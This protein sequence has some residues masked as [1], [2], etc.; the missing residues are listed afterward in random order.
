LSTGA[1]S[2]P[3]KAVFVLLTGLPGCV[4]FARVQGGGAFDATSNSNRSGGFAAVDAA[5]VPNAARWLDKKPFPIALHTGIDA[6][7]SERSA[8]FGWQTGLAYVPPP[9]PL[10]PY[11]LGGTSA[12]LGTRD[13]QTFFGMTSPYAEVGVRSLLGADPPDGVADRTFLT[14]A[15][16][17]A[18]YA[19]FL[20]PVRELADGFVLL[21]FGVGW[22]HE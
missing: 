4:G 7:F 15:L 3:W 13:R 19:N 14:M 22:G 6:I 10:A 9:R 16:S 18:S 2:C 12:H 21:K 11:F 20:G 1:F 8:V 5:G 17:G